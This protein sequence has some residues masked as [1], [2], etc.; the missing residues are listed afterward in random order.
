MK[1]KKRSLILAITFV[2]LLFAN[3]DPQIEWAQK[4]LSAYASSIGVH[5]PGLKIEANA[6]T[7]G[8]EAYDVE[9]ED[10]GI[11]IKAGDANGAKFAILELLDQL[12]ASGS[13]KGFK[14][15]SSAP[16][17]EF[18]A[19]KFNL[20]WY[21]YRSNDAITL[22]YDQCRDLKYWEA[23][24]DMMAENRFNVLSLWNLHPWT[25]LIR[26]ANFPYAN[27]MNDE[28]FAEWQKLFRGIFRLAEE[29][30]IDT[31]LVNWNIFVSDAFAEHH[32]IG[33]ANITTARGYT[34][35]ME[36]LVKR[37]NR[38]CITQVL[39]E[40]PDLDGVGVSLGEAMG[41]VT[42]RRR[43]CS[44]RSSVTSRTRA[45]TSPGGTS[46]LMLSST[47]VPSLDPS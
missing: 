7:L 46:R 28:E 33:H 1:I 27:D 25:Y 17:F 23:W 35:E 19:I 3:A 2:N 22:H 32:G 8:S 30:G 18:R 14:S 15:V 42:L 26:P 41:G 12:K 47:Q 37:Y 10:A 11:S 34:Q 16:E 45:R 5:V 43:V 29:R 21:A 4:R 31:Y 36:D 40:Y 9:V 13:A 6:E 44:A 20:P 38:E 39:N 24:M